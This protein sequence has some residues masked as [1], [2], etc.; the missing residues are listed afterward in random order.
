MSD[1]S[2][3]KT[4]YSS[5]FTALGGASLAEN[6]SVIDA[7]LLS[8]TPPLSVPINETRLALGGAA[9]IVEWAALPLSA[10]VAAVSAKI[11][12]IVGV[13]TT[14]APIEIESLGITSATDGTLVDKI[15]FTTPPLSKGTYQVLWTSLVGMLATVANTGVRGVITLTR[16]RGATSVSR[17][18]EHNWTMQQPQTFGCGITFQCEAGDTIRAR[19]QVAK[20]G[21]AAATAQ[22][23][24]ARITIDQLSPG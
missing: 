20:V 24:T 8:I 7:A 9:L 6:K 19:L 10:D 21:V 22:M 11:P 23:A 15:D 16:T 17:Q 12:T 18:W 1:E 13:A 4:Y 5:E 14:S 2:F 3:R